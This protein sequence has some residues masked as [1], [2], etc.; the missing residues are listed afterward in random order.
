[1]AARGSK[2]TTFSLKLPLRLSRACLGKQS[3]NEISTFE[4][5]SDGGCLTVA[6]RPAIDGQILRKDVQGHVSSMHAQLID[7][8]IMHFHIGMGILLKLGCIAFLIKQQHRAIFI[9]QAHDK[10][11]STMVCMRDRARSA[12]QTA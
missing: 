5:G 6:C 8:I 11:D 2:R 1:M 9:R 4:N 10:T 7:D 12:M 3:N